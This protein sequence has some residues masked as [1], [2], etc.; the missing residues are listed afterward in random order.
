VLAGGGTGVDAVEAA[1]MDM[2]DSRIFNAGLGS[3]ANLL[4]RVEMDAAIMDGA[5]LRAGSVAAVT[6]PK[7]PVHLAR[8]VMERTEHVMLAAEGG[9]LF[10][11]LL[12]VERWPMRRGARSLKDAQSILRRKLRPAFVEAGDT[13]GAIAMD[14]RGSLAASTSTGGTYAKLPGRV[15]DS[16]VIGAGCYANKWAAATVTGIGEVAVRLVLSKSIC[17]NTTRR[18]VTKGIE[19]SM[20]L[21]LAIGD[22]STGAIALDRRGKIAAAQVSRH[23]PWA[24]QSERMRKPVCLPKAKVIR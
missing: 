19:D 10:A 5:S 9:D 8:L 16:P 1:V 23:M 22:A 17:D 2:E 7:N 24:F 13:V 3:N 11:K 18:G 6:Y 14:E 15:G 4:E 21:V 20:R 12:A